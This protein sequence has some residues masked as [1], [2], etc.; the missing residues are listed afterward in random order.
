MAAVPGLSPQIRILRGGEPR[1][2]TDIGRV[3]P[4][5][6]AS[7]RDHAGYAGL[8]R[9]ISK[10]GP[11]GTIAEVEAAQLRGRGGAGYPAAAKW[12]AC[13]TADEERK[14]VVA[15]LMGADPTALGDRALAE[16]NPHLVLEGLLIAAFA[17]GASEAYIAIRRDW[18]LAIERLRAAIA[19]AEAAHL[20]GYLMLGT[21]VSVQV[22]LW[23]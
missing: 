22:A 23:E 21:D 2:L 14:V 3:D 18:T 6:L 16:G 11:E 5:S 15:N 12:R 20:A 1:L 9:A 4:T 7:Y 10:L 17:V 19:E 8:E 13:R